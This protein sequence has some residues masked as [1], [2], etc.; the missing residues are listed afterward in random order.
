[1]S[2]RSK[3]SRFAGLFADVAMNLIPRKLAL[4]LILSLTIIVALAE[5]ISGYLNLKNQEH[6]LLEAWMWLWIWNR[7]IA[8]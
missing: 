4:K 2:K 3:I 1:M 5:G 8:K 6:Q 7:L